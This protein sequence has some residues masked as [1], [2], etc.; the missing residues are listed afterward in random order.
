MDK[1]RKN[2][3]AFITNDREYPI[4]A[5]LSIGLYMLLFYYSNNFEHATSWPQLLFA[6]G[7]YVGVPCIALYGTFLIVRSTRFG[8]YV[9]QLLFI[10]A[11][12]I[13]SWY[14]L[15]HAHLPYSYKKLFVISVV[16]IVLLSFRFRNYKIIIFILMLMSVFPAFTLSKIV[17]K[18]LTNPDWTVQPDA[19]LAAKF[20]K[21]P[22]VYYIQTD[23][24]ANA[25]TLKN[26]PYNFD[27][28]DF[29]SWLSESGFTQYATFKSNYSSTLKSN[30]SCFNMKHH[31]SNESVMFKNAADFILDENPV[32]EVFRNNGYKSFFIAEKPYM[33]MNRPDV[34]FDYT[35]FSHTKLP[36]L[37]DGWE[38]TRDITADL[39]QQIQTNK[40]SSNFFFIEKFSPGHIAVTKSSSKGI[41]QE[42]KEYLQRLAETNDWL[43]EVVGFI[44]E[45]DP[46]AI[47]IIGADHGGFVGYEYTLEIFEQ[48]R[49]ELRSS[50]FG[51]ALAIKWNGENHRQYDQN[52]KT[53]VNL[54]RTLFAFLSEDQQ[55]LEHLQPDE[56][57][58]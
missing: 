20:V 28:S 8:S 52:L 29:D 18:N 46:N 6:V 51:A 25:N 48:P 14:V 58:Y 54:F 39:K 37:R 56:N 5:G 30:S 35:N 12:S 19:I 4:L 40:S 55:Y 24:Y 47:I 49:E 44:S 16:F 34:R 41:E 42:R 23:G 15:Q 13:L 57:Y 7:Y 1:I 26:A 2:L 32:V 9:R 21:K 38:V 3:E 31:Y 10:V 27:N 50:V 53:S 36:F 43:E 17:Y 33:L 45:N 11:L 22:N